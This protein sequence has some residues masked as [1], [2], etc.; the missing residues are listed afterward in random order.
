[1]ISVRFG[2]EGG[3]RTPDTVTRMPH[4]ECGAFNHSATSPD[5]SFNHLAKARKEQNRKLAPNWHRKPGA[6]LQKPVHYLVPRPDRASSSIFRIA[7]DTA[8]FLSFSLRSASSFNS[9]PES[10]SCTKPQ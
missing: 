5:S 6:K 7:A 3:I 2:G 4:F 8:S 10:R 1:M 9:A